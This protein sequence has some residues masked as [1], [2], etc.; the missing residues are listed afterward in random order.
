MT[1][2][3][4]ELATRFSADIQ[5]DAECH[6]TGVASLKS[7][8]PGQISFFYD[9]HYVDDL[10][11]TKASAVILQPEHC[12]LSKTACLVTV[13][14][15]LLFA[16]IADFFQQQTGME[17][18]IH[19]DATIDPDAN[20]DSSASVAARA[21][22]GRNVTIGKNTFI[23]AGCVIGDGSVVGDNGRLVANVCLCDNVQIGDRALI[24]PGAVI[25]SDGFGFENN[26][27]Q[28]LKVPQLGTVIIGDDVE[29]GANTTID[30]GSLD[31]TV[32]EDGV[33]LDN[34]IQVAHNVHIG[35][36]TAIAASTAIAGSVR[37]GRHCTIAGK[38]GITGHLEITDNVH[39]TGM[40]MVTKSITEAGAYSSGIPVQ[41]NKK[42]NRSLARISQLDEIAK[43][44][45]KVEKKLIND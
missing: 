6:I 15:Q 31:D 1:H 44:L 25:G 5:G 22:I 26:D 4:G 27:G 2:T 41:E 14:P 12:E 19:P 35:A 3:L 36:H 10:A 28:W 9:K 21:V 8:Q 18:G 34:H 40:S 33:K 32:I 43:R 30:C 29:I 17:G 7:A 37:I 20:I 42:W 45:K 39:I 13:N 16:R 24:H 38:V 11:L 23:G